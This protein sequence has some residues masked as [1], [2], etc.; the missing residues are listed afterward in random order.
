MD[1]QNI[2]NSFAMFTPEG[3]IAVK[4][5]VVT[6][7]FRTKIQGQDPVKAYLSAGGS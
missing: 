5:I 4:G 3:N 1:I 2:P 6:A 7:L